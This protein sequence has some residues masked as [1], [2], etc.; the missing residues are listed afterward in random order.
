MPEAEI[1]KVVQLLDLML[2]F[3]SHG[4][5]AYTTWRGKPDRHDR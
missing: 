3:F 1:A 5:G 4:D 2:E